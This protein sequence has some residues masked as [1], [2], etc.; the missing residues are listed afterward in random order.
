MTAISSQSASVGRSVQVLPAPAG[1][2][3]QD[4]AGLDDRDLLGITGS[5]LATVRGRCCTSVLYSGCRTLRAKVVTA[6]PD[7]RLPGRSLHSARFRPR[8]G[9][10]PVPAGFSRRPAD[11]AQARPPARQ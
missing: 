1:R 8:P 5:L 6:L 9:D 7:M 11:Y 2:I 3:R 10:T 4:L